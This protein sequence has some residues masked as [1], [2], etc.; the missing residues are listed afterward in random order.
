MTAWEE[1]LARDHVE[2]YASRIRI[3]FG[4]R[5]DTQTAQ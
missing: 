4:P 1:S 2:A 3:Q 5:Y